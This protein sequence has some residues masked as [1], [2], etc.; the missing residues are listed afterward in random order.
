MQI[1]KI[2]KKSVWFILGIVGLI[3]FVCILFLVFRNSS[4]KT[5]VA[6]SLS[7]P[8]MLATPI[9]SPAATP[10]PALPGNIWVVMQIEENAIYANGFYY[11]VATFFNLDQPSLTVRA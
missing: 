1:P 9:L 2:G 4:K 7:T 11:D 5:A 6:N 10:T 3:V 8:V